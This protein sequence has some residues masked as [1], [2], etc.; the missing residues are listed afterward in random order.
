MLKGW[1]LIICI[2]N[3]GDKFNDGPFYENIRDTQERKVG[4]FYA[5][6]L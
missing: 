4:N 6:E 1:L 2:L 5:K 3:R